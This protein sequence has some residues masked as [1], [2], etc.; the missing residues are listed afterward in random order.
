MT[1]LNKILKMF[2]HQG[3][4]FSANF[5]WTIVVCLLLVSPVHL[6]PRPKPAVLGDKRSELGKDNKSANLETLNSKTN[7]VNAKNETDKPVFDGNES[8]NQNKESV[9]KTSIS[10]DIDQ[11]R[12]LNIPF[13]AVP[14]N[15]LA[16]FQPS[17]AVYLASK[18]PLRIWALGSVSRFPTFLEKV[19]F[20]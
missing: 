10:K 6:L 17:N 7:S 3:K 13:M 12:Q 1:I 8:N 11:A 19:L 5:I 15:W 18:D 4:W 16:T 9:T 20:N 14:A 2:S